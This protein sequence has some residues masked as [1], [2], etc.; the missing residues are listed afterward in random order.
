M[1]ADLLLAGENVNPLAMGK[2]LT[3][4]AGQAFEFAIGFD[5]PLGK[6]LEQNLGLVSQ[7]DV[8][9]ATVELLKAETPEKPENATPSE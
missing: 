4:P 2:N 7:Q 3:L 6:L 9:D 5:V 1:R 8:I